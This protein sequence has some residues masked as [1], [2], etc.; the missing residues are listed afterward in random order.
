MD[1]LFSSPSRRSYAK[2]A[3]NSLRGAQ[4]R[5]TASAGAVQR[6]IDAL[7]R[8]LNNLQRRWDERIVQADADSLTQAQALIETVKR[9]RSG[10]PPSRY[11]LTEVGEVV[12]RGL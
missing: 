6:A 5:P 7:P 8:E 3:A 11:T 1:E 4:Q 12:V 10:S 2:L 9:S